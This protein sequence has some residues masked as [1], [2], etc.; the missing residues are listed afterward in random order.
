MLK[1]NKL[2]FVV[3]LLTFATLCARADRLQ[4]LLGSKGWSKEAAVRWQIQW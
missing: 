4:P 1:P 3:S 2:Q